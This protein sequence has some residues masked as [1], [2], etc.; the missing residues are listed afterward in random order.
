MPVYVITGTNRGLGLEFV[1]QLSQS[2]DNTIIAAVRTL[3]KDHSELKSLVQHGNN[4]HILECDTGNVASIDQF[5][6][7]VVKVLGETKID[8]LLNNSGINGTPTQNSLDLTPESLHEHIDVNVIG[9]QRVTAD[10]VPQLSKDAVVLNMTS[11]LGSLQV[12]IGGGKCT[13]YSISKAALNM[14]TV[15]QASDLK[16]RVKAV[17]VMDPGWVKTDM[18]GE[19][20]VMEPEDSI[21]G[22]L[23][24]IHGL[25]KN[26]TAKFYR[27][28]GEEVPW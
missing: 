18:G 16:K 13:V 17:I 3:Q 8:Y 12:S 1:R 7:E 27:S 24:V 23:K 10:L 19:G 2:T 20:A 28:N 25:T 15:H 11:G 4:V 9:P 14:L 5:A 21:S 22:M 26:D 6:K